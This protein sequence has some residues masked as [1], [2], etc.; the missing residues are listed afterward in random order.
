M[1]KQS[2]KR[3]LDNYEEDG[4]ISSRTSVSSSTA[5]RMSELA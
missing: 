2:T 3:N 1:V 5:V 4:A